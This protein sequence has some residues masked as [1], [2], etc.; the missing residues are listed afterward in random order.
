M[1]NSLISLGKKFKTDKYQHGYLPFYEQ[2][3][4]K[5][6]NKKITLL[7]IGIKKRASGVKGCESIAMWREYFPFA[8]IIGLDIIDVTKVPQIKN[9]ELYQCD[10]GNIDAIQSIMNNNKIYPDIIIDDG[11]HTPKLHQKSL[12]ALFPYLKNNGIYVI[13][14]LQTC[15]SSNDKWEVT[16][17]NNTISYL[18]SIINKQEPKSIYLNDL[19]NQY[20]LENIENIQYQV[21]K[22]I[23]FIYKK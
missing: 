10:C 9:T 17:E 1:Q 3:F 20:I 2:E 11:G 22:K 16:K 5:L 7:E 23:C 4:L 21:N 14:D 15:F 12:S 18:D 6:K 13:E 8:R 19:E